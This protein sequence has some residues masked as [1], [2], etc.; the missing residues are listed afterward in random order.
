MLPGIQGLEAVPTEWVCWSF[1]WSQ[2]CNQAS[3]MHVKSLSKPLCSSYGVWHVR[4]QAAAGVTRDLSKSLSQIG[5]GCRQLGA[6]N[7]GQG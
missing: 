6:G 1:L 4:G 7:Q 2:E 3:G 5:M